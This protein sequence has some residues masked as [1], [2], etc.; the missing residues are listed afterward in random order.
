MP[1]PFPYEAASGRIG[2]DVYASNA[3]SNYA[4]IARQISDSV[5]HPTLINVKNVRQAHEQALLFAKHLNEPFPVA[6]ET[7]QFYVQALRTAFERR[8]VVWPT[9]AAMVADL[10]NIRDSGTSYSAF[11]TANVTEDYA[12]IKLK[13][14]GTREEIAATLDKATNAALLTE[15]AKMRVLFGADPKA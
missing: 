13:A 14:D 10:I 9:A 12:T 2:L 5:S 7:K 15:I 1:A 6:F 8:G 11:V 3:S 4:Q